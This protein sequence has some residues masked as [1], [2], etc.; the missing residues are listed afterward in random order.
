MAQEFPNV[1]QAMG[2]VNGTTGAK[3]AGAGF[4]PAFT[5]KGEY[6]L[7]LDQG[8]DSTQCACLATP[9]GTTAIIAAVEQNSDTLKIVRTFDA[10]GAAANSDF[11]FLCLRAPDGVL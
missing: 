3:V 8:A 5:A 9:R 7:T 4:S 6:T 2:S 1:V 10:A 11:D